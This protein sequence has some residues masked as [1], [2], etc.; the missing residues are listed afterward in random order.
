MSKE[1]C[2]LTI[3]GSEKE[4]SKRLLTGKEKALT[5]KDVQ[6]LYGVSVGHQANLRSK[7]RGPKFYKAGGKVLYRPEDTDAYYFAN[8]FLTVD[9][10]D[11]KDGQR[12]KVL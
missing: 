3:T 9:S 11:G 12:A 1:L 4:T 5:P 8:P 7:R 10:L 6:E 2:K